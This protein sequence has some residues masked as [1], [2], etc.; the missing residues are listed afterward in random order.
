MASILSSLNVL[1]QPLKF[2]ICYGLLGVVG[3]A[4]WSGVG[5]HLSCIQ[6]RLI[7]TWY[8][9]AGLRVRWQEQAGQGYNM[10]SRVFVN[11]ALIEYKY[12]ILSV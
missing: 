2:S 9:Y 11:Q 1:I 3:V 6:W 4:Y 7:H 12:V 8:N 10:K 5:L